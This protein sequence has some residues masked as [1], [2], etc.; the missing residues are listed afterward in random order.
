[1]AKHLL[2]SVAAVVLMSG[3][4][5]AQIYPPAPPTMPV[6]PPAPVPTPDQDYRAS[7]TSKGMDANGNEVTKKDVYKEGIEGRSETHT[8]TETDP[9]GGTTTRSTTTTAPR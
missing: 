1:M 7:T 8:K 9:W 6:A 2:A 5:S 4:A 3:V